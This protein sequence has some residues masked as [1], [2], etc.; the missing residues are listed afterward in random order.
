MADIR[1]AAEGSR[2]TT[3][4]VFLRENVAVPTPLLVGRPIVGRLNGFPEEFRKLRSC[5][6]ESVSVMICIYLGC[7]AA[8]AM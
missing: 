2:R 5:T 7:G 4:L 1:R 8:D 6:R 3:L